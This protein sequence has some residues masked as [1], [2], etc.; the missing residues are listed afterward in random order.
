[1]LECF[2]AAQVARWHDILQTVQGLRKPRLP[3][4]CKIFNDLLGWYNLTRQFSGGSGLCGLKSS[5]CLSYFCFSDLTWLELSWRW[6]S[7]L[8]DRGG[9]DRD[10]I[11]IR[12]QPFPVLMTSWSTTKLSLG[13]SGLPSTE[14]VVISTAII[15]RYRELR[16][17]LG[18]PNAE[19]KAHQT[20]YTF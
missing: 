1:M 14:C 17:E 7:L 20:K 18:L 5:E 10:A 8:H 2:I 13:L 11:I 12:F 4:K 19:G 16:V 15:S 9:G 3:L 6:C